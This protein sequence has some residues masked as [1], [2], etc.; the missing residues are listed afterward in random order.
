MTEIIGII[1][2]AGCVI[3]LI[4]E[5]KK[6]SK[7]FYRKRI[8]QLEKDK[9]W[10]ETKIKSL[11]NQQSN[12]TGDDNYKDHDGGY[13]SESQ[14]ND[15]IDEIVKSA[16]Y[17]PLERI[18]Y[19]AQLPDQLKNEVSLRIK[20]KE[21]LNYLDSKGI[22]QNDINAAKEIIRLREGVLGVSLNFKSFVLDTINQKGRYITEEI[23]I[24]LV[25]IF[26]LSGGDV[27][28]SN[29]IYIELFGEMFF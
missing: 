20:T 2:I 23:Y 6:S 19:E 28:N 14:F 7:E 4:L 18:Y 26:E 5:D 21:H 29:E 16:K 22:T 15:A 24:G 12:D 13:T 1:F 10:A 3:A 11:E 25:K 8:E 9:Y 17:S 27:S